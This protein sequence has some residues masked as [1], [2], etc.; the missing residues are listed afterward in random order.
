MLDILRNQPYNKRIKKFNQ[1][2]NE[3]KLIIIK[4]I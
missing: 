3:F 1:T 2:E 4:V